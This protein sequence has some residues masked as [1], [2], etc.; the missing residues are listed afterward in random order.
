MISSELDKKDLIKNFDYSSNYNSDSNSISV[1]LGFN[2]KNEMVIEDIT[3]YQ[4][5]LVSGVTGSGKTSFIQMLIASIIKTK[6]P[7]DVQFVIADSRR[8]DYNFLKRSPYL[9]CPLINDSYEFNKSIKKIYDDINSPLHHSIIK[10]KLEKNS[11]YNLFIIL[12][13]IGLFNRDIDENV[14]LTCLTQEART[15]NIHIIFVTSTPNTSIIPSEIKAN[16]PCRIAFNVASKQVSKMII[17]DYGAEK[18]NCP[19]EFL[20]K[21]GASIRKFNVPFIA[22]NELNEIIDSAIDNSATLD[23]FSNLAMKAFGTNNDID[24]YENKSYFKDSLYKD[25]VDFVVAQQKASTSLLQR[26][27]GI[28]YN[29]AAQILDSLEDNG[30]V[31][32]S[33]GS[34][35]R[36]VLISNP[37]ANDNIVNEDTSQINKTN[38]KQ[39]NKE[40]DD[41]E[42]NLRYFRFVSVIDGSFSVYSNKVHIDKSFYI[43]NRK[44]TASPE[45][46]GAAIDGLVLKKPT[47]FN[48]TGYFTIKI[49]K[50]TEANAS[51]SAKQYIDY[52]NLEQYTTLQFSSSMYKNVK[53]FMKQLSEDINIPIDEI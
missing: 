41:P 45:F 13:D 51:G 32:P 40:N 16:I 27:F 28:G 6:K 24:I 10:T 43:G 48:K 46:G 30:I 42:I 12:D 31:G 26:R 29:R 11:N 3:K 38:I 19:G 17:D 25:A 1:P 39:N 18:L 4:H 50:T 22:Y 53:E 49:K 9:F 14:I 20:F 21:Y 36:D 47:F 2:D 8:V 7:E 34:K 44:A 52:N 33:N 35:P 15:Y 37:Y 23:N 5:I